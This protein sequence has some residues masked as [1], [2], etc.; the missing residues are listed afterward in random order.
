MMTSSML[1]TRFW[2]GV[3]VVAFVDGCGG[4]DCVDFCEEAKS[5]EGA[6]VNTNGESCEDA[7]ER[8]EELADEAGCGDALDDYIDC[9]ADEGVCTLTE[10][11]DLGECRADAFS[12]AFCVLDYCDDN[13]GAEGC[14]GMSCGSS[15]SGSS[16]SCTVSRHCDGEPDRT[17]TCTE[18]E[19]TCAENAATTKTVPF[20][21]DFC[22]GEHD[23]KVN[24]AASAC[25][26]ST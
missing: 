4:S 6:K 8:A 14:K 7:C 2:I 12:Y 25:G 26:W 19:C 13:P 16:T 5:C 10:S 21:S 17:L 1:S 22:E 23:A 11:E 15:T 20:Q 3:F 24:A 9:I 18:T